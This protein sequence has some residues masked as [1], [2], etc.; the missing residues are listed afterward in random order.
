MTSITSPASQTASGSSAP[1]TFR[2]LLVRLTPSRPMSR[3]RWNRFPLSLGQSFSFQRSNWPFWE[4]WRRELA[5]MEQARQSEAHYLK[6]TDKILGGVR[7]VLGVIF[8]AAVSAGFTWF[9]SK[10]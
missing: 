7:W 3:G 6:K 1:S 4:M 5:F 9:F 10:K 2:R 8:I